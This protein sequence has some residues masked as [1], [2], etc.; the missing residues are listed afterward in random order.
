M[1]GGTRPR[2][3]RPWRARLQDWDRPAFGPAAAPPGRPSRLGPLLAR[4]AL[5]VLGVGVLAVWSFYVHVLVALLA[6]WVLAC[7]AVG[8]A[9][10]RRPPE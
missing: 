9:A 3:G 10:R 5:P 4:W 1:P 8:L 7:A 2:R 6:L